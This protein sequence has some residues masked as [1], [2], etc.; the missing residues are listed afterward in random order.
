MT[1]PRGCLG[2]NWDFFS[3]FLALT[4]VPPVSRPLRVLTIPGGAR[5]R[6]G[7]GAAARGG[8]REGTEEGKGGVG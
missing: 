7:A 2:Q 8:R 5:E 3:F 4:V 1:P 6:G